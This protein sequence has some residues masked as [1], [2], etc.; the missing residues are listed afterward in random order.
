MTDYL[1]RCKL[2]FEKYI[3]LGI[4]Y[5]SNKLKTNLEIY[6]IQDFKL[7][8]VTNIRLLIL[9]N[10]I[11]YYLPDIYDIFFKKLNVDFFSSKNNY[12]CEI[13]NKYGLTKTIFENSYIKDILNQ[14]NKIYIEDKTDRIYGNKIL[15]EI[16]LIK[17]NEKEINFTN[18]MMN[19][20]KKL[21]LT[22]DNFFK[23]NEIKYNENDKIYIKYM[24]YDNFEEKCIVDDINKFIDYKINNII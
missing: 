4:Y 11:Y 13:N 17:Y 19:I 9:L 24:N 12:Y 15:E 1:T 20:D 14:R 7:K 23:L 3:E 2:F 10:L 21:N 16:K 6:E 22:L 5:I 18:I 8:K